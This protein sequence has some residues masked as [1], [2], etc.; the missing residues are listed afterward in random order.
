MS[1]TS[2][3]TG[4]GAFDADRPAEHVC[5]VEVDVADVVGRVVVA[6]LRVGPLATLDADR[7]P[8][9]HHRGDR[10]VG[11]PSV[12]AGY[13]LVPHRLGL[14]DREHHIRHFLLRSSWTVRK[15]PADD[16]HVRAAAGPS[17]ADREGWDDLPPGAPRS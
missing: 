16:G 17:T 15:R 3:L 12:V 14:V 10:D 6:D 7:L 4:L 1:T 11:V 13:R 2:M 9:A 8:R 5:P